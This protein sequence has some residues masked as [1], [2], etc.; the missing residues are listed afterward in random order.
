MENAVRTF[1]N[2]TYKMPE[3]KCH[4]LV[5]KDCSPKERFAVFAAQLDPRAKTK[6]VTVHIA[7]AEIKF[8]PPTQPNLIQVTVDGHPHELVPI[9]PLTLK[10]LKHDVRIWL[11]QTPSD[12]VNPIAVLEADKEDVKVWYDGKNVKVEVGDKY[13]GKTCGLCGDNNDETDSEFTGPDQCIY[14]R[15][16]DFAVSYS[17]AGPHCNEKPVPLGRKRCPQLIDSSIERDSRRGVITIKNVKRLVNTPAGQVVVNQQQVQRQPSALRQQ[18]RR[19]Q[20]DAQQ[21]LNSMI[22]DQQQRQAERLARAGQPASRMRTQ[23]YVRDNQVCFTTKPILAC[24]PE[25]KPVGIQKV[26]LDFHCLDKNVPY[27]QQLMIQAQ[28]QAIEQL[29]NKRVHVRQQ[30]SVPV[31]CQ[32]GA[33]AA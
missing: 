29:A 3:N 10:G 19:R 5:A 27:T 13:Q 7:G 20:Q 33:I 9:K 31:A 22:V 1:D 26:T 15:S 28:T 18:T 32:W 2:I 21:K 6:Q 23:Y 17:L 12:A 24:L 25:A 14:E 4:Y 16:R 30:V 8:T 11:Q